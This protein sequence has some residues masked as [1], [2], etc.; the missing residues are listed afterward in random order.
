VGKALFPPA[1][2][3]EIIIRGLKLPINGENLRK[4]EIELSLIALDPWEPN[5]DLKNR[6]FPFSKTAPSGLISLDEI[7]RCSI[8]LSVKIQDVATKAQ[9]G[10]PLISGGNDAAG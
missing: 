1:S 4:S 10:N 2:L 3:S 5:S 7:S 9:I 8:V 6:V